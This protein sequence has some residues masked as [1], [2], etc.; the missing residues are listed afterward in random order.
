MEKLRLGAIRDPTAWRNY[1]SPKNRTYYWNEAKN[2]SGGW[3]LE[4]MGL[5]REW[6]EWRDWQRAGAEEHPKVRLLPI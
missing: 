5:R 3:V 1:T 4:R 6:D 2:S